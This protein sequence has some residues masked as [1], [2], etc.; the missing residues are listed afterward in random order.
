MPS[1]RPSI[2]TEQLI[3]EIANAEPDHLPPEVVRRCLDLLAELV[4]SATG[5]GDS[6]EVTHF[7][8]FSPTDGG[9]VQFATHS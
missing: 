7:G 2:T 9:D 8:T 6:V 4:F 3:A 5:K 1:T